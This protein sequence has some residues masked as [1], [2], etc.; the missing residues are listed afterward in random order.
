M[1]QFSWTAPVAALVFAAG[2]AIA[3]A[4]A[5]TLTFDDVAA[6]PLTTAYASQG[7]TFSSTYVASYG[8]I[9]GYSAPNVATSTVGTYFTAA[10]AIRGVFTTGMVF[11]IVSFTALDVGAAGVRIDAFGV[12]GGLLAFTQIFGTGQGIDAINQVSVSATDIHSFAIYQ[13]MDGHPFNDGMLIDNLSFRLGPVT[14]GG[15]SGS[16]APE[17]ASWA[18]MVGGFGLIGSA[19]RS[20]RR[21][22]VRFA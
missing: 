6:A 9:P 22:A 15:G 1:R 12:D 21:S 3:P 4:E 10:N 16:A 7:V 8:V 18:M 14:S 2:C 19:M 11:Q 20:R 17:P 13:A 5:V